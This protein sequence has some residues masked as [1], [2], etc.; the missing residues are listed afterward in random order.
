[1][2]SALAVTPVQ[3][4]DLEISIKNIGLKEPVIVRRSAGAYAKLHPGSAKYE[5]L[6]GEGGHRLRILKKLGY[7]SIPCKII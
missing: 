4:S 5:F 6:A 3:I 1:M 2:G 7:T